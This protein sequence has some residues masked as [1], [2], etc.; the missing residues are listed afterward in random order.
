M[1]S[2]SHFCKK[3]GSLISLSIRLLLKGSSLGMEASLLRASHATLDLGG[4]ACELSTPLGSNR[5]LAAKEEDGA[6]I[7]TDLSISLSF[8]SISHNTKDPD[9]GPPP[10]SV[11]GRAEARLGTLSTDS[12]N[13]GLKRIRIIPS[14]LC[15]FND[16]LWVQDRCRNLGRSFANK[17]E[18]RW[19]RGKLRALPTCHRFVVDAVKR[20]NQFRAHGRRRQEW[21][22]W[23][24]SWTLRT[25]DLLSV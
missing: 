6:R 24:G 7:A 20:V 14:A 10:T 11:S 22:D 12:G 5:N 4:R 8:R 23:M 9:S 16:I 2:F 1:R 15:F 21:A 13:G 19:G 17:K 3:E 25:V 18:R